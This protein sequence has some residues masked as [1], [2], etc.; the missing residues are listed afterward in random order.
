[1]KK[2]PLT[3]GQF[4]LIDDE[5]FERVNSL[6]WY[7]SKTESGFRAQRVYQKKSLFMHRFLMSAIEGQEVDHINGNQLDNRKINLRFCSSSQNKM[8]RGK[9]PLNTSGFKGVSWDEKNKKWKA[10]IQIEGKNINL[11]RFNTK[12]KAAKAYDNAAIIYHGKFAKLNY[13]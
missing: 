10:Q 4:A 2:I 9:S 3:K 12:E 6:K 5:D 11:G 7:A 13:V 1:M 8:N